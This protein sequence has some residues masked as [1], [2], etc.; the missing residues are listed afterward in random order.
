MRR[1]A[2]CTV[3]ILGCSHPAHET[4][5]PAQ[6]P[7]VRVSQDLAREEPKSKGASD[8]VEEM[9]SLISR[10]PGNYAVVGGNAEEREAVISALAHSDPQRAVRIYPDAISE[11]PANSWL[12]IP[13][14]RAFG[15][16]RDEQRTLIESLPSTVN[17]IVLAPNEDVLQSAAAC[18]YAPLIAVDHVDIL[19]TVGIP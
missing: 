12:V 8:N 18:V 17:R 9:R 15:R 7:C 14:Q 10:N 1:K 6:D 19:G 2:I 16:S 11:I 3:L 5:Q 4:A 13:L